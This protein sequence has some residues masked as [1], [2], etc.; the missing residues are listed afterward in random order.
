MRI[1]SEAQLIKLLKEYKE[2]GLIDYIEEGY[3]YY[4]I[5]FKSGDRMY[6][7]TSV[8]YKINH[9]IGKLKAL[10]PYINSIEM[11]LYKEIHPFEDLGN[12]IEILLLEHLSK[13]STKN[14]KILLNEIRF[15]KSIGEKVYTEWEYLL[16][17]FSSKYVQLRV[18]FCLV[19]DIEFEEG[20]LVYNQVKT[21]ISNI[22]FLNTITE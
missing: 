11:E 6:V 12:V 15:L 2:Q 13:L 1:E 16:F 19:N 8:Y 4:N 7:D 21:L 3:N 18:Q 9:C 5:Y 14:Q 10:R 20:L 22:L 17:D